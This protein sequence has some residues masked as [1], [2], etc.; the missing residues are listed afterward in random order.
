VLAGAIAVGV[1]E[2]A[3][4]LMQVSAYYQYIWTGGLT[5]IAVAGYSL[6]MSKGRPT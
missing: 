4:N 6:S 3:L 2:N 1:M 5:L